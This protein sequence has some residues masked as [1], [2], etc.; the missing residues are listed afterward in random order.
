MKLY[1]PKTHYDKSKRS[2]VF[3][4]LKPF[5]KNKE[6]SDEARMAMYHVSEKDVQISDDLETA[7]VAVLT[8]SY[9]YYVNTNLEKIASEFIDRC[10]KVGKKVLI[11]NSGDFGV[12]IPDFK[13]GIIFRESGYR[14][15]FSPNEF[16][17]PS[18]ISDPLR[19]HYNTDFPIIIPFSEKPIIGFCG[20]ANSSLWKAMKELLLI[21]G[22]NIRFYLKLSKNEPQ[23]LLS[24]TYLRARILKCFEDSEDCQTNFI[25]RKKYRAGVTSKKESHPMTMEFYDNLKDSAYIVCVRGRGNFSVRFYEA[26]AMGRIPVLLDTD[27]SLPLIDSIFWKNH[28]VFVNSE[29]KHRI[30]EEVCEFHQAMNEE[31]FIQLQ[32]INRN[33]WKEK[34]TLGGFFKTFFEKDFEK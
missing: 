30:V 12:E 4:L 17:L 18:F 6:F 19:L 22:R 24:S 7:D 26:L 27:S 11:W 15:K 5:I 10:R 20:Q 13:N 25:K 33:L 9:N 8:M 31:E 3:P 34:L 14:S 2:A 23:K 29:N 16:T 21:S 1:Y 32:Q 28:I